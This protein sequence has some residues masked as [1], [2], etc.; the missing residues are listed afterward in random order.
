MRSRIAGGRSRSSPTRSRPDATHEEPHACPCIPR[1]SRCSTRCSPSGLGF[2][3]GTT[4]ESRRAA[5]NCASFADGGAHPA[6]ARGGG[7]D[8]SGPGRRDPGARVPAVGRGP[9]A[10]ARVVPRRRLGDRLDRDARSRVPPAVRGAATRSSCRSST[11]S[12]PRRSSRARS[13]TASRRGRGS[14][15]TRPTLGGDPA[16]IAIGGDSAGGNLAAVVAL[17]RP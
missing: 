13:T 4:P 14:P 9:A 6:R 17:A 3:P 12:R 7:P 15:R 10:D 2:E 16:R 11:A 1:R 8:P 5:M